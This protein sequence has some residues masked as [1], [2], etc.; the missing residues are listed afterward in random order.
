MLEFLPFTRSFR[1]SSNAA[2]VKFIV[3]SL[4]VNFGKIL[5]ILEE[6]S[7]KNISGALKRWRTPQ[8]IGGKSQP[9][10]RSGEFA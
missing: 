5:K 9:C 7:S 4:I 8:A 2:I 6:N 1:Y 3:E 10:D